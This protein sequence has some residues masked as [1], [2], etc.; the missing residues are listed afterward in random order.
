MTAI[1]LTEA[2]DQ[3]LLAAA[4]TGPFLG[5][6]EQ[7][8]RIEQILKGALPPPV[9][10][11][12][13][14]LTADKSGVE[15]LAVPVGATEAH[16]AYINGA[17]TTKYVTLPLPLA[18]P[19]VPPAG[20][21]IVDCIAFGPTHEPLAGTKWAGRLTTVPPVKPGT[22]FTP[23]LVTNADLESALTFKSIALGAKV[24]RAE[25]SID[26]PA[27]VVAAYAAKVEA[28]GAKLL[29]LVGFQGRIPTTSEV[30]ALAAW[31]KACPGVLWWE[32]G[33]ETNYQIPNT[34]ANGEAYGRMGK[35][36]CEVLGSGLVL[37]Q[38]SDAGSGSP[39][40]LNGIF[41]AAPNIDAIAGG[42][43]IHPYPGQAAAGLVD[44]WGIPMMQRM[45]PVLEAHG[46]FSL[47]IDVT[48]WGEPTDGGRTL[49]DGKHLT[50]AE[51]ATEAEHH[52]AALRAAAK[53][54]VRL[55]MVYQGH[56][57]AAPGAT[58]NRESYFGL[59]NTLGQPKGAYTSAIQ[60]LLAS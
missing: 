34:Q 8:R 35:L 18:A 4:T 54:R 52:P 27:S 9:S 38:G 51:A 42:W 47:P 46:D 60:K 56:D 3:R 30:Q 24:V 55:F 59:L 12:A 29:V 33:N 25:F 58:P 57:N 10:S 36:A 31:K 41:A 40:W 28:A 1:N 5:M 23:G 37:L 43:T 15:V 53:G 48:E 13:I 39:A 44:G 7:D 32:F 16:F 20:F 21:P 26:E 22:V 45:V 2:D 11:I 49:S 6:G 19:Y 50:F 17:G 14:R